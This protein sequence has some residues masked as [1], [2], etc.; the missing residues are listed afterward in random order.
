MPV[1]RHRQETVAAAACGEGKRRRDTSRNRPTTNERAVADA[2]GRALMKVLTVLPA[3]SRL[4]TARS[5]VVVRCVFAP[6]AHAVMPCHC[7]LHAHADP[8]GPTG[9]TVRLR[10]T[11]S[12][13]AAS[14]GPHRSDPRRAPSPR[15]R[16]DERQKRAQD[17][18]ARAVG[19]VLVGRHQGEAGDPVLGADEGVGARVEV[20][21]LTDSFRV[22]AVRDPEGRWTSYAW[23]TTSPSHVGFGPGGEVFEPCTAREARQSGTGVGAELAGGAGIGIL[24][25]ADASLGELAEETRPVSW[26]RRR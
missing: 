26:T 25:E 8:A 20:V 11:C 9:A 14:R 24:V 5:V 16:R 4:Q 3:A 21:N 22:V 7:G 18:E 12:G 23:T 1:V 10:V 15:H 6:A 17:S 2:S 13:C 19:P